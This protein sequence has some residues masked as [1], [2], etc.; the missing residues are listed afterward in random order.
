MG[1]WKSTNPL[2]NLFRLKSRHSGPHLGLVY[3]ESNKSNIKD[4]T[5]ASWV[6]ANLNSSNNGYDW[7]N[8]AVSCPQVEYYDTN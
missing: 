2:N 7:V 5:N 4:M 1:I 8:H 3:F 6:Q